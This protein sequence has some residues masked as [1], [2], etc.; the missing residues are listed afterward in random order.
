MIC[1]SVTK[2]SLRGA[3]CYHYTLSLCGGQLSYFLRCLVWLRGPVKNRFLSI[4]PLSRLLLRTLL[5][6]FELAVILMR[7]QSSLTTTSSRWRFFS[8]I[9]S[10]LWERWNSRWLKEE[11][12]LERSWW[13]TWSTSTLQNNLVRCTGMMWYHTKY[14]QPKKLSRLMKQEPG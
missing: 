7:G 8:L 14:L 10:D 11:A 3:S 5:M 4:L 2:K 9:I 6:E 12:F 13:V 1:L